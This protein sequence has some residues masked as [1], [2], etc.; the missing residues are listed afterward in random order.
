MSATDSAGEADAPHHHGDRCDWESGQR[1][2]ARTIGVPSVRMAWVEPI[3]EEHGRD[4]VLDRSG[5][6]VDRTPDAAGSA[7]AS[8][9]GAAR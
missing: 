3:C 6:G 8:A 9:S 4:R 1:S 7:L 2:I 5:L